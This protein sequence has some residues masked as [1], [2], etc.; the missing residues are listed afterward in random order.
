M[1]ESQEREK[2]IERKYEEQGREADVRIQAAIRKCYEHSAKL[3]ELAHKIAIDSPRSP[4]PPPPLS[5]FQPDPDPDP[6]P[7]LVFEPKPEP[8]ATREP[9][10]E[11]EPE[12]ESGFAPPSEEKTVLSA[13]EKDLVSVMEA[14][15]SQAGDAIEE[16]PVSPTLL[17]PPPAVARKKKG[18][19][20]P[21]K[22]TLTR[23]KPPPTLPKWRF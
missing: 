22:R 12:P 7:E 9:E 3:Q 1:K 5:L 14:L 15:V 16:E 20:N 2:E 8:V 23:K 6:M 21:G 19:K 4:S 11:P 18:G 10:P 13:H 17:F